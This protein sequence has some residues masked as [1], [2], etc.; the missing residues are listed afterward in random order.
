MLAL[1]TCQNIRRH[2]VV[3]KDLFWPVISGFNPCSVGSTVE[4]SPV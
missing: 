4:H 2:T 1:S 3:E